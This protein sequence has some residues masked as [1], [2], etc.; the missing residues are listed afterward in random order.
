MAKKNELHDIVIES[1]TEALLQIMREKPL[2]KINVSELCER[3]GVSRVSYYRNYNSMQDI[4]IKQLTKCT[5]SWWEG[6]SQ[7][8]IDEFYRTFLTELLAQYLENEKLIRLLYQNDASVI[9]KEHIFSCCGSAAEINDESAYSRAVLAGAIYGLVDEWIRRGMGEL[10]NGFSLR[11][12]VL[13][14]PE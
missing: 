7:K 13:A 3:A 12:M 1:L 6:F 4:L 2:D 5:D 8:P 11:R 14:M 10:P 9:L